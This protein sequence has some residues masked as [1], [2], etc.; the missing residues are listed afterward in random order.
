MYV[1][2]VTLYTR[3]HTIPQ[4]L[5]DRGGDVFT[6]NFTC[7]PLYPDIAPNKRMPTMKQK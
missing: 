2:Y 3:E 4:W 5:N 1:L 7:A 6:C